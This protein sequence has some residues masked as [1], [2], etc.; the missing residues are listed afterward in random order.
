M[1]NA[2]MLQ[3]L[4]PGHLPRPQEVSHANMGQGHRPCAA[5]QYCN[6][7]KYPGAGPPTWRR[8][9]ARARYARERR[10]RSLHRQARP[11]REPG[12]PRPD[13]RSRLQLHRR[14]G[15]GVYPAGPAVP[16]ER[17][18]GHECGNVGQA[19]ASR[20]SQ[21]LP[22]RDLRSHPGQCSE[23]HLAGH[24]NRQERAGGR[25]QSCGVSSARWATNRTAHG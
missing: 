19:T 15:P 14:E 7:R 18:A 12:P 8:E 24:R 3:R 5:V 21:V 2:G 13:D 25:R 22:D 23:G 1:T 17:P 6:H 10:Q 16:G 9:T 4:L 11:E 20:D